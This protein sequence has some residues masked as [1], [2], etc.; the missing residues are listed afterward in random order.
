M[1]REQPHHVSEWLKLPGP[2][3]S[4]PAG[5]KQDRRRR[6]LREERQQSIAREPPFFIHAAWPMR[7]GNLKDRLC[8]VD[9]DGRMLHVG[10]SLPWPSKRPLQLGTMMPHRQEE[11]IPS[12]AADGG[13]RDDEPLAADGGRRDDEPPAAEAAR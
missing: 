5:L 9:G 8:E 10:S 6:P 12:L 1:G 4:R 7:Y 13:R 11:S 3:V 2:V